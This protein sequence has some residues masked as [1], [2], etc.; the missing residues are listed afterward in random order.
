V[1][2]AAG[3]STMQPVV[4]AGWERTPVEGFRENTAIALPVNA[5][6]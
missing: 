4:S 5:A 3:V 1:Q 2:P 6:T